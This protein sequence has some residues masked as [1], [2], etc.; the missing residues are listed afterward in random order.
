MRVPRKQVSHALFTLLKNSYAWNTADPRLQVPDDVT[1]MAQ[2]AMF[3]VKPQEHLSQQETF[4][5]PVY[6]LSYHILISLRADGSPEDISA[7]DQMDDILDAVESALMPHP[8]EYQTLGGLVTH[9]WIDGTISIDT[10]VLF[11]QCAIWIP[12]TVVVGV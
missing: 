11:Q 7:E 5:L 8:G 10:P 2:P 9:C 1:A 6:K 12:I 3:L 4:M